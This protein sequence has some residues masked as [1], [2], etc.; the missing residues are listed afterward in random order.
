MYRIRVGDYRIVYEVFVPSKIVEIQRVRHR[1]RRVPQVISRAQVAPRHAPV[2]EAMLRSVAAAG[3]AELNEHWRCQVQLGN[4]EDTR[5]RSTNPVQKRFQRLQ[6][7]DL[8]H[9]VA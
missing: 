4:E 7:V 6:L 1:K 8:R 9:H 5:T 3:E 2:C